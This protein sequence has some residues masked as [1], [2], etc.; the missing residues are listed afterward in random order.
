MKYATRINSFLSHGESMADALKAIGNID[1]LDYVDL[2]YPEH[3][4]CNP[5][6]KIKKLLHQNNLN[7][8]AI[9]LRFR[10]DYIDGIFCNYDKQIRKRA[11]KLCLE[12]SEVCRQL[13]GEQIIIWLGYDGFDYSFQI[14]YVRAWEQIVDAFRV[15]C[16]STDYPLSIEYKPYG[17][18]VYALLDSFGST[19]TMI[20]E[21]NR[22]N[23]GMTLD[24]CH[25]LMKKENPA[26]AA[27]LLLRENKLFTVHLNDGE[28][29]DD[30]GL[31][32]GSVHLWKILELYY[33]LKKYG[34]QGIIYFDTFP[35]RE[36]AGAECQAN[37]IMCR[38]I[39]K[40]VDKLGLDR[41][42]NVIEQNDSVAVMRMLSE[43]L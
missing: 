17:E 12:A 27:S 38:K 41:I 28:G 20:Q 13:N 39:E 29:W 3:F 24:V 5:V 22:P 37:L 11:I 2:N 31:M 1:G 16:D 26:F 30:D 6:E 40:M 34:Y 33:Y 7:I 19:Y 10:K 15:V 25:M 21:V 35:V 14:D 32:V 9:N 43:L 23:L 18:R 8:N 42:S 4:E 36:D